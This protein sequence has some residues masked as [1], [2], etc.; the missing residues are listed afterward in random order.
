MEVLHGVDMVVRPGQIVGILGPNGMGKT[1]LLR[2]IAGLIPPSGGEIRFKG[3]LINRLPVDERVRLGVTLVPEGRILFAGLT[4]EENLLLGAYRLRRPRR[5][6]HLNLVY[7]VFPQLPGR[8]RQLA[9]TLSGGQQQMLAI[10]R[11]LMAR[12]ELLLIDEFSLGL[13]PVVVE[14]ILEAL[15]R[16]HGMSPISMVIVEQDV[17]VG[18]HL[19]SWGYVLESGRV[20]LEDAAGSLLED[21]RVRETYLGLAVGTADARGSEVR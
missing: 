20:V 21:A 9:G 14:S 13:A 19:A 15:A 3:R 6:E 1:T 11:G 8:R 16:L 2:A 4:V 10:G 12:P 17:A 5:L 18:L 7:D